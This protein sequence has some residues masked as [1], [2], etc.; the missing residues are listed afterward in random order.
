MIQY[1]KIEP[2]IVEV[3]ND[4]GFSAKVNMWELNDIRIQIKNEKATG[5]YVIFEDHKILINERGALSHWPKGFNDLLD[6][7]LIQI[8]DWGH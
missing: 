3:R 2:Q 4:D 5:F 6:D 1:N 7:Q 8:I